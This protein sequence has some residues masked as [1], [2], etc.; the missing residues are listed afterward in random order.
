VS[1][2]VQWVEETT[3]GLVGSELAEVRYYEMPFGFTEERPWIR[4]LA[5]LVDYGVDLVTDRGTFG[6]TWTAQDVGGYGLDC[7]RGPL[8]NKR[9]NEV[10]VSHVEDAEPWSNLI[11]STIRA[12]ELHL[13]P[14]TFG[15]RTADFVVALTLHFSPT[16]GICFVCGSWDG[17]EKP[18]FATGDDIVVIWK[19]ESIPIL[20][21]YFEGQTLLP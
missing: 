18:V 3:A 7:V 16:A 4:E 19:S 8:L 12:V 11:R 17:D 6:I 5:H 10:Q 15:E 9:E 20:T 1:D 13:L 2:H 14:I 21:P